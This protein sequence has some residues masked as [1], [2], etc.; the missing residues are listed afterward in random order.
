MLFRFFF[1]HCYTFLRCN[2]TATMLSITAPKYTNPDGYELTKVPKPA[3]AQPTDVLIRVRA[4]SVN[5]IDV[6]KVDGM[7]K[8]AIP[9]K[10]AT[11]HLLPTF[12]PG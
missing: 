5:P 2:M 9:D 3:V 1:N 8:M 7:M 6:K 10:Y 11:R 12:R 4:A